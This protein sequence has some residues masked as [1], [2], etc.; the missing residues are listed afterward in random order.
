MKKQLISFALAAFVLLIAGYGCTEDDF[1]SDRE[2]QQMIDESLNGQWQIVPVEIS[3]D[4]WELYQD[5]YETYYSATVDLPELKD[6]IFMDGASLAYY[7]FNANSKTA[8]PYVKTIVGEDGIP[9][10]ETYSCDF[11]LGNP[12]TVTFYLEASDAGFYSGNPPAADFDIVL[13]Y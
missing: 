11:T 1:L 2:I 10:T 12:S 13:I 8:L 7:Y 3:P 9:F 5:D 6:Y 4:D